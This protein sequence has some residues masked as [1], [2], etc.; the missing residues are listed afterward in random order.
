MAD[1]LAGGKR[2]EG[3]GHRDDAFVRSTFRLADWVTGNLRSVLVGG[4]G[5]AIIIVGVVYYINFQASVREQAATEL[6]TL[7]LGATGP[8]M[9]IPDLEAYVQ[10]FAGVPAA[11]EG[12]LLLARTYLNAGQPVEA[13]R[14]ANEISVAPDEP[15]GL[16]AQTLRAAAQEVSGDAEA[17]VATY[18]RLGEVARFPFQRR[19]ARASAARVLT[20]LGRMEE[21]ETIYAAIAEEAA[22]EDPIEAS[23]YRL[24]LGEVKAQLAGSSG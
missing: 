15:V 21:A 10:R 18:Q 23:V 24:R 13:E 14:V 6:A 12:R 19:E 9:L 16:A 17:A 4:A 2:P 5:I 22:A 8:E 3:Q 11:D 7:R 20:S 1:A